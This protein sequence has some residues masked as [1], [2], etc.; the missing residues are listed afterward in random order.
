MT[1]MFMA[2]IAALKCV[3]VADTLLPNT[4]N[5]I[6]LPARLA[7][8]NA[9]VL[10]SNKATAHAEAQVAGDD[11]Q[12]SQLL[13]A[14]SRCGCLIPMP[15]LCTWEPHTMCNR[16]AHALKKSACSA[17]AHMLP[18]TSQQSPGTLQSLDDPSHRSATAIQPA[19]S[20]YN[21]I[22]CRTTR[23]DPV[24]AQAMQHLLRAGYAGSKLMRKHAALV[25]G[26]ITAWSSDIM[27]MCSNASAGRCGVP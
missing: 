10:H 8:L 24:Q 5:V 3:E 17:A 9:L 23:G 15:Q 22:L 16:N 21:A 6:Q 13:P 2:R 1:Y 7:M 27:I 20:C 25:A 26:A 4:I 11:M 19:P 14:G 12:R 18:D